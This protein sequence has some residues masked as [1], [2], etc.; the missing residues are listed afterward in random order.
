[1]DFDLNDDF[2]HL[3]VDDFTDLFSEKETDRVYVSVALENDIA[4]INQIY[5]EEIPVKTFDYDGKK[6]T[7]IEGRAQAIRLSN[8]FD[9]IRSQILQND[10]R[11]YG[12]ALSQ[13]RR[14]FDS[15]RIKIMYKGFF[16]F[17]KRFNDLF[18][19][20]SSISNGLGFINQVTPFEEIGLNFL[21]LERLEVLFKK[22]IKEL[23][24][25]DAYLSQMNNEIKENLELYI[26][27][28][29]R[30]FGSGRYFEKN[31]EILGS[32]LS[33]YQ[34]V[35]LKRY[36]AVKKEL[37]DYQAKLLIKK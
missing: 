23:L 36:M 4:I 24:S 22:N 37:L 11:I 21:E 20:S 33:N 26:S 19:V 6:Y 13:E 30:Y 34:S 31:L 17:D 8:E 9:N 7:R 29:W 5:N 32:A 35:L 2:T 18:K 28:K 15:A 16:D 27:R 14:F 1:M 3:L 12:L 25:N 10:K